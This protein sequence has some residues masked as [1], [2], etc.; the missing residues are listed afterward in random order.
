MRLPFLT[1]WKWKGLSLKTELARSVRISASAPKGAMSSMSQGISPPFR[2]TIRAVKYPE[3]L[4]Q[5]SRH[6]HPLKIADKHALVDFGL[7]HQPCDLAQHMGDG[8]ILC[9]PCGSKVNIGCLVHFISLKIDLTLAHIFAGKNPNALLPLLYSLL[10]WVT[11]KNQ[12]SVY[13][14]F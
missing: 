7:W 6:D 9:W 11:V 14:R 5:Y 1:V 10:I 3:L 2:R 12:W 8:F 4:K 13:P